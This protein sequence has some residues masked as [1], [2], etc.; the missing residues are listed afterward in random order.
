[1]KEFYVNP[2]P[3][4]CFWHGAAEKF[5]APNLKWCEETLCQVVSEPANTWSNLSFFVFGAIILYLTRNKKSKSLKWIPFAYLLMG[6]GS[7]YYHMSNFYLSQICDFLGMFIMM[8]W[9]IA[10]NL[11]RLELIKF[12]GSLILT[13]T[14]TVLTSILLHIL[15]INH[16]NIQVLIVFLLIPLLSLEFIIRKK[17]KSYSL[18]YFLIALIFLAIAEMFSLLDLKRVLCDPQN[19]FFQGHALWHVL[20][21]IGLFIA[22]LFYKQFEKDLD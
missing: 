18:K 6:A 17:D 10:L 9:L 2:H 16:L 11:Q 1:M 15:Y 21:S 14:M 20:G 13:L 8:Y 5:G 19:H 4:G 22:A 3:P 12:K 7:F